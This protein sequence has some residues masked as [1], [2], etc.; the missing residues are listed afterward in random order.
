MKKIVRLVSSCVLFAL[1]ISSF[2][3][4]RPIIASAA[5]DIIAETEL[6]KSLTQSKECASF[7]ETNFSR[8]IYEYNNNLSES[9]TKCNATFV[10][11]QTTIMI[12]DLN[13]YGIYLD[14]DGNNG[15]VVVTS[16]Y[17]LFEF[18]PLGDLEYLKTAEIAYYN[19]FDKF[20]YVDVESGSL[21][22]YNYTDNSQEYGG[23]VYDF[24]SEYENAAD[25]GD[26][27]AQA[28][29]GDGG[30]FDIDT[31]VSSNYPEFVYDSRYIIPGYEWIYQSDNSVY[32]RITENGRFTEGNCVINATYSMMNDWHNKGRFPWL[33]T[34]TIDY[35]LQVENDPFFDV[36]SNGTHNGWVVKNNN[37]IS[38]MASLYM[39]LR[40]YAIEYGYNM[41]SGMQYARII[42]MVGRVASSRGFTLN[43][44]RTSSF[45]AIENQIDNNRACLI[46]VT[47]S[48]TYHNHAMGL[49]GYVKYTHTTGWWIFTT[50]ET[51]YF[52][53][54]DDGHDYKRDNLERH[55][56]NLNGVISYVTYFDPNTSA[57]PTVSFYYLAD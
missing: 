21:E 8:F 5:S 22:R 57:N 34:G 45:Q 30:I 4:F 18:E 19:S 17:Q 35:S 31:Y 44:S 7:I 47:N 15:Y 37:E 10:E 50:T 33:P 49:Y 29:T 14:F 16:N 9:D 55:E 24:T 12:T 28:L 56:Y 39:E 43:V 13:K 46:A 27:N 23:V 3:I 40:E 38:E 53:V 25:P 6:E 41:E 48:S 32:R 11:G 36:Y 2:G 26:E 54:V 1:L 52:Y 42:D 51:K 20:M